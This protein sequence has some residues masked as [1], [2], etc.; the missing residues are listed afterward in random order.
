MLVLQW[1]LSTS[2][3]IHFVCYF[4][5]YYSLIFALHFRF[6]E[7]NAQLIN[8]EIFQQIPRGL[9]KINSVNLFDRKKMCLLCWTYS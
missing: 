8:M 9:I 2:Y 1:I 4:S 5:L 3:I 7:N 6:L